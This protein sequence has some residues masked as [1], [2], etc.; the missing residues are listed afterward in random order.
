MLL[1][2]PQ[3]VVVLHESSEHVALAGNLGPV[4]SNL[5]ISHYDSEMARLAEQWA[6]ARTAHRKE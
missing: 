3:P 1:S 6:E 2:F 4:Q 5:G